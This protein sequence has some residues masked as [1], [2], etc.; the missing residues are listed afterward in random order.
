M[1]LKQV[2]DFCNEKLINMEKENL[3]NDQESLRI[4]SQMI[5][6]TKSKFQKDAFYNLMWGYLVLAATI[7]QYLMLYVFESYQY[8]YIGWPILMTIGIVLS[9]LRY[10]KQSKKSKVKTYMDTFV[11]YLWVGFTIS[12]FTVL[13]FTLRYHPLF[14]FPLVMVLYAMATFVFG[15]MLKFKPLIIGGILC[16]GLAIASFF[17]EQEIQFFFLA[18]SLL[19][20]YIIPGH[21]MHLSKD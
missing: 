18:A 11:V 13:Y 16:W 15:G 8:N 2:S 19:V 10:A 1:E 7:S 14:A 4:I 5:N 9:I 21:L 3:L 12:L 6:N 20:A 17:V